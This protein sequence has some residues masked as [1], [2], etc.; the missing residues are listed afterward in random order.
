VY[1]LNDAAGLVDLIEREVL[2][3]KKLDS[4]I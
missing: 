1:D 3:A 4:L 2:H